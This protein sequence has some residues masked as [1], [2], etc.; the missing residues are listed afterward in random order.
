MIRNQMNTDELV[1]INTLLV[2][3]IWF[4]HQGLQQCDD[5]VTIKLKY[6]TA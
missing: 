3:S 5:Q 6:V 1:I 4:Q 2:S